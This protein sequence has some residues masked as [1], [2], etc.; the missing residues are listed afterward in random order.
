MKKSYFKLF[1]VLFTLL[2]FA[3]LSHAQMPAAISISPEDATSDDQ[4][5]LTLTPDLA[6][7]QSGTLAGVPIVYMHSGYGDIA[8]NIWQNVI[9][10][11]GVG[12]DGTPTTLSP[13]GDG[14]YS[15]TYTPKTYYGIPDGVIVTKICAV[16]N[17]GTWDK[18]A[19]DFDPN[20]PPN[21][22]DFFIPLTYQSA[23]PSFS[24]NVNMNK[25][26]NDGMFDPFAQSVYVVIPSLTPTDYE[27]LDLDGDGIY[28][29]IIQDGLT[30]DQTY[31]YQFRID[32]DQYETV[33][34]TITAVPGTTSV[35]VWWN[36]V[37]LAQITFQVDMTYQVALGTFNPTT[38]FVDIAG[39]FNSWSGTLMTALDNNIWEA[40]INVVEGTV[41]GFKFR[42]N[43]DWNTSEFPNGGPNRMIPGKALPYTVMYY[44][45]DYNTSTWPATFNV[46][47]NYQITAGHFDP[48][49]DYLDIAGTMNGWNGNQFLWDRASDGIYTGTFLID[50]TT[51][52]P[53]LQFKFRIN[54]DWNTSEF[55]GGGP[56][57][58]WTVHDTT[59]GNPN[60]FD[61]WYNDDNP[62]IPTAPRVNSVTIE[63]TPEVGMTLTGTYTYEDIN[64]DPES[65]STYQ[66]YRADDAAGTNKVAI[67]DMTTIN[68]TLVEDDYEKY[69]F[70]EVTPCTTVEPMCGDP[71]DANIGP[72]YHT[73]INDPSASEIRMYPNPAG[74]L[75]TIEHLKNVNRIMVYNLTGQKMFEF[76][77]LKDGTLIINTSTLTQ[78]VYF[79]TFYNN[80]NLMRT[81]KFMKN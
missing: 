27:L 64:G 76:N 1:S 4:L 8:G 11:N 20:N 59:G 35:N 71:K 47:M 72:I 14:T 18:D 33:Q 16:F 38:D 53:Q 41:Y 6:C 73:G 69:V 66:W 25:M 3:M 28:S 79:V 2:A 42:I 12:A 46:D 29:G 60:V 80:S 55:P 49:K 10:Y 57:R 39:D 22:M 67:A 70:F 54:S 19:R 44:Y 51:P 50:T 43:G 37:A 24:F 31:D 9:N 7:F 78:G 45:D 32:A 75:L 65:G 5:T 61:C 21:C 34:R 13:N 36:D 81:D 63:G 52:N 74:N 77:N 30:L 68:Y 48:A 40:T 23:T 15:I 58:S 26:I 62:A 17:N 56:N